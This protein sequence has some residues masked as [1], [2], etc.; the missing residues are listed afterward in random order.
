LAQRRTVMPV[1]AHHEGDRRRLVAAKSLAHMLL[2]P[3]RY[4][5]S[6]NQ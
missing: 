6:F 5:Q 3:F 1:K 2:R 4:Y